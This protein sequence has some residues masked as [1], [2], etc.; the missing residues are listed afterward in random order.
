MPNIRDMVDDMKGARLFSCMDMPS[1][2]WHVPMDKASIPKTA[3]EVTG[4]KFEMLHMPFGLKN[5]QSTQQRLMDQVLGEVPKTKTYVDNI[6]THS[7]STEEHFST[8]E[9]IFQQIRDS[10]LSSPR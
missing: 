1:A 4:G 8:L 5:S 7:V 9:R 3:F 2:Y 10:N 6:L